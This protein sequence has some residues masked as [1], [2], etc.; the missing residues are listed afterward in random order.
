MTCCSIGFPPPP[1]LTL[2]PC[3][4]FTLRDLHVGCMKLTAIGT[5]ENIHQNALEMSNHRDNSDELHPNCLASII[6]IMSITCINVSITAGI[7]ICGS[8]ILAVKH[9]KLWEFDSVL[10][11]CVLCFYYFA[12]TTFYFR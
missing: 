5:T 7:T 3:T 10:L 6:L 2:H 4:L 1:T 8:G 9:R 12:P 11:S